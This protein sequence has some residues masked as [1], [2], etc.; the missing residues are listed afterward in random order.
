MMAGL[1]HRLIYDNDGTNLNI[2]VEVVFDK[3]PVL[4]EEVGKLI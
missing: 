4:I 1:R 3:L 2:I